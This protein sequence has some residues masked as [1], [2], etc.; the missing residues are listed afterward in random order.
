[1]SLIPGMSVEEQDDEMKRDFKPWELWESDGRLDNVFSWKVPKSPKLSEAEKAERRRLQKELEAGHTDGAMAKAVGEADEGAGKKDQS[2]KG[3][4]PETVRKMLLRKKRS[5]KNGA[6]QNGVK[7]STTVEQKRCRVAREMPSEVAV[8][9]KSMKEA[10]KKEKAAEKKK[11]DTEQ[12]A[13]TLVDELV[14][15]LV[16]GAEMG[17]KLKQMLDQ[18]QKKKEE[19]VSRLDRSG[20]AKNPF[21]NY[22]G[23]PESANDQPARQPGA[24]IFKYEHPNTSYTA[25]CVD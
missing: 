22:G 23:S 2:K 12:M 17:L 6:A 5:S 8:K 10:E 1:M 25:Q 9:R 20:W 3:E 19:S 14:S 18:A 11:K 21:P 13:S 7:G 15:N 4:I 24:E 16:D